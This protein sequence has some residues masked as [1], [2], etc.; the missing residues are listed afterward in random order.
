MRGRRWV[1]LVAAALTPSLALEAQQLADTS[2]A[3]PI[4]RPAFALGAGPRLCVDE[5]HH[6]FHTVDGRFAPFASLSRRDGYRVMPSRAS[7]TA[8]ALA[9]CDILVIANA[10]PD[11]RSW[12]EYGRPTPS[13]FTAEEIAAVHLWVERGGALLMLA[14]HMPLA[15]AAAALA[16]AFG[17]EFTDGFAYDSAAGNLRNRDRI[18]ARAQPTLFEIGNGTLGRHAIFDGRAGDPPVTRVRSFTG[19]AFR[20][21]A[22]GVIPLMIL[23]RDY[24]SLEPEVAWEFNRSTPVRAVGGWLQGAARRVGAGRVVL[25]GEA[26]MLSAQRAGPTRRP[27]GMNAEGAEQNAQF[28]LNILHW[29]SGTLEPSRD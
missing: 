13:A 11:G 7:F 12:S 14:D 18:A 1:W 22:P 2:Y 26:A 19:Q 10:Q 24:V 6:N 16:A 9:S 5:A 3:P 15:G 27:M 17:A 23:P 4:A 29:L 28:A 21:D 20:W 8:D 25:L